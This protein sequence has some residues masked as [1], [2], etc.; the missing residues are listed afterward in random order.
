MTLS[1]KLFQSLAAATGKARLPTVDSWTC[2]T[3][4]RS[5]PAERSDGRLW[6]T[7]SSIEGRR[8]EFEAQRAE[9][10]AGVLGKGAAS[11]GPSRRTVL[12]HVNY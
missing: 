8:A 1:G 9:S 12:P 10:R 2:G 4:R 6:S 11:T 5:E 3:T 7:V